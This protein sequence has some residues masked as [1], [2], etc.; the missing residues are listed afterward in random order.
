M[1]QD[2]KPMALLE[3]SPTNFFHLYNYFIFSIII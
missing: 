2:L 3:E 1:Q